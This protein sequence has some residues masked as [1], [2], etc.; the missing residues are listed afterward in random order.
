MDGGH[1]DLV[2][3]ASNLSPTGRNQA[4]YYLVSAEKKFL[5]HG[6]QNSAQKN[7]CQEILKS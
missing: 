5:A 2:N 3:N 6:S 1:G 4:A 7:A